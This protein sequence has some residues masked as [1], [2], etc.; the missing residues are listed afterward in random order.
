M[1]KIKIITFSIL[2][3][4]MIIYMALFPKLIHFNME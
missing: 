3:L 2:D 1:I 4:Y